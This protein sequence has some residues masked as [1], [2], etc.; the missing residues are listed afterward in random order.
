MIF[1]RGRGAKLKGKI[2]FNSDRNEG[3]KENC[4]RFTK[5]R[6]M[7]IS[8]NCNKTDPEQN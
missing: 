5:L 4:K 8:K 7:E 1:V 2:K 6:D 3:A